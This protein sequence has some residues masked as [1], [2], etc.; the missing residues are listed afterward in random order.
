MCKRLS[1]IYYFISRSFPI[2]DFGNSMWRFE[3]VSWS[4]FV[5]SDICLQLRKKPDIL[6]EMSMQMSTEARENFQIDI[7]FERKVST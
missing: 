1:R 5:F 6:H 4:V 3:L 2:L 7:H